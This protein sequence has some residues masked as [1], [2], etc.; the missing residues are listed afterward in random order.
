R[1]FTGPDRA[2][3]Q[4]EIQFVD[5][6]AVTS[7]RGETPQRLAAVID[8]ALSKD[9]T[10]RFASA[11]EFSDAL[12][13]ARAALLPTKRVRRRA[14]AVAAAAVLL[15]SVAAI[16]RIAPESPLRVYESTNPLLDEQYTRARERFI[17]GTP[18]GNEAAI[19]ILR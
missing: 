6:P 14:W 19:V 17:T 1:P 8:R 18:Q 5:P 15:L 12:A 3:V 2:A 9:R 4:H 10:L 13:A 11:A 16:A 7:L